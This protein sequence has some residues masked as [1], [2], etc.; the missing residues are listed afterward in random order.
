MDIYRVADFF[1]V[2]VLAEQQEVGPDVVDGHQV[3]HRPPAFFDEALG[4]FP[5]ID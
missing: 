1:V 4:T 2:G 5:F 3:D